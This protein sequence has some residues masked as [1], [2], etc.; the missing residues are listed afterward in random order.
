MKKICPRCKLEKE[1]TEENFY[2]ARPRRNHKGCGWQSYCKVC[3]KDI[4]REQREKKK[5]PVGSFYELDEKI[6]EV[7]ILF[8]VVGRELIGVKRN[9]A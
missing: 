8:S 7:G 5:T 4:N 3:W 6:E 2:P 1:L 9:V